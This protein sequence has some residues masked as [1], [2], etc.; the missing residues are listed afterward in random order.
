[1]TFG[2]SKSCQISLTEKCQH[3]LDMGIKIT[4]QGLDKRLNEQASIFLKRVLEELLK[5]KLIDPQ[6]SRVLLKTFK[7]V[8]VVDATSFQLPEKMESS[9]K[10][11]GGGASKSGIKN[12]YSVDITSAGDVDIEVTHGASSD[13][14][15]NLITPQKGILYLYDLGYFTLKTFNNLATNSAFYLCRIK[16]NTQIWIKTEKGFERL[17]WKNEMD[18]MIVGQIK[19]ISVYIGSE[20]TVECRLVIEKVPQNIADEK[21]RKLKT[22]KVNKRKNLSKERLAFCDVNAFITNTSAKQIP[23]DQVRSI[24]GLRWQIEIYFKTW[25]SYMN[26]DKIQNMNVH[27]FNCTHY[28]ALIY[29]VLTSKMFFYLKLKHWNTHTVELSELKAMNLLAKRKSQVEKILFEPIKHAK[30]ICSALTHNILNT[31]IK[32][33][34]NNKLT[35]FEVIKFCLS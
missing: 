30:K 3:L 26:I 34:K 25:K 21:R 13:T 33:R 8:K 11:F 12:H 10:G 18:K 6:Q 29:I 7:G 35:P 22:D 32:E 23:A 16:S 19:E 28:G 31:C 5:I 17:V 4:K 14:K 15:T 27:R 9:Y 20:K 1:M 24:Y 2:E